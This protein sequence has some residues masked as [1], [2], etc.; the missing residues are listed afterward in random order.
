MERSRGIY[1]GYEK[2]Q[3][4]ISGRRVRVFVLERAD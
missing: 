1:G 3:Q 4:R 2:Y